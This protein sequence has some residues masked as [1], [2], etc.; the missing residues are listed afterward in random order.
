M[1][2]RLSVGWSVRLLVGTH[3]T[4]KTDY[5]AIPSRLGFG[6][7]LVFIVKRIIIANSTNKI[8]ME[9]LTKQ[10]TDRQKRVM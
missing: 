2:V 4:S 5:V 6:D 1:L 3:I 9:Q 7:P 10:Q 8:H